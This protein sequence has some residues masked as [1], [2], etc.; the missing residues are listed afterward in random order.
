MKYLLP[1]L[2]F[3]SISGNAKEWDTD[4]FSINLPESMIVETDNKR[5]LLAFSESGPNQPPFLSIEAGTGIPAKDVLKDLNESLKPDG[6]KMVSEPCKPE[7]QAFYYEYSAEV[8]GKTVYTYLYF[9]QTTEL[10]F[11]ISYID[12]VSLE[13]GRKFVKEIG[14]QIRGKNI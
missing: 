2:L 14:L 9:V 13:S 8:D 7:C 12:V 11:I 4:Y 10:G 6:G 1:L 3:V 5:R